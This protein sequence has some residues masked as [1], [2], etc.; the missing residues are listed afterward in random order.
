MF[1]VEGRF[2][3]PSRSKQRFNTKALLFSVEQLLKIFKRGK[4]RHRPS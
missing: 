1:F 4:M 3:V 2:K